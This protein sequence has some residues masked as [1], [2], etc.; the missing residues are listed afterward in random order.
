MISTYDNL[1]CV[2]ILKVYSVIYY[3]LD[4]EIKI[5][6]NFDTSLLNSTEAKH[7]CQTS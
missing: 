2:K 5:T 4:S 3:M 6:L 1:F 7:H